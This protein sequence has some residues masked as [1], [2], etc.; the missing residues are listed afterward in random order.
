[1]KE[2]GSAN[3]RIA[4]HIGQRMWPLEDTGKNGWTMADFSVMMLEFDLGPRQI[5]KEIMVN[6]IPHVLLMNY[7]AACQ[8]LPWPASSPDLSPIEHVW[9]MI[10]RRLHLPRNVDD[11]TNWSK[12][13]KKYY[14]RP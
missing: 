12:F 13:G 1:M 6:Y 7:L 8:T 10:R 2:A 11:L 4:R 14:R 5:G 9:D 3:Q